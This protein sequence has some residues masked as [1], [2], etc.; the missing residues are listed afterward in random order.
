MELMLVP[1]LL[2]S[3]DCASSAVEGA[4]DYALFQSD[5][6]RQ[7]DPLM[8]SISSRS[9]RSS[10]SRSPGESQSLLADWGLVVASGSFVEE[11]GGFVEASGSCWDFRPLF[12]RRRQD[13]RPFQDFALFGCG[14]LHAGDTSSCWSNEVDSLTRRDDLTLLLLDHPRRLREGR[15][16]KP[17]ARE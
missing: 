12:P 13:R 2:L 11:T 17:F 16:G 14:H 9:R 4:V 1:V 15:Q 5:V 8:E 3:I 10:R 7:A 6:R